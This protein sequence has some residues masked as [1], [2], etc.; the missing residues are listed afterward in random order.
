MKE[1][2][3]HVFI[4]WSKGL[5]QR[6]KI[7][8]DI[9]SKFEILESVDVTWSKNKFSENLSRFYGENLPKNSSKEKHCG[10]GTFLC[11]IVRDNNPKYELRQTSKGVKPVNINMFD[12][13]Q[14]YR[15]WTGGG[16]K[17]HGSDNVIEARSNMYLLLGV[18]YD[19]IVGLEETGKSRTYDKNLIGANGW[20]SLHEIF[21]A[22]NELCNYVVLRNFED[23]NQEL[24]NLHPDID[25]LTDNKR[26]I[27][28]ISNG[29]PTKKDKKRV[30]HLVSINNQNVFFDFR[31]IGDNYYDYKWE[32]QIL[33]TRVI[34]NNLY[35]PNPINHFY[36][37]MY[38]AFIHKPEL[39]EDYLI[40]LIDISHDIDLN[41]DYKSFI[42][43][44][45]LNDLNAFMISNN[46]Q[47]V[48]PRDLSVYFNTKV[49]ENFENILLSKKR[50]SIEK[51]WALKK[52]V[53]R[54]LQK[55]GFKFGR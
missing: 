25:L 15:K 13:K 22:F 46:Y 16:H 7:N 18:K 44:K 24:N 21:E 29:K 8:I 27:A 14:L 47:Y 40:K 26:L 50:D 31:F 23:I 54:V 48:E 3:A 37:L 38:H 36:S 17:I 41:Y 32:Q 52:L 5:Q 42:N 2:E 43:L 11:V 55:M 33:Y 51:K 19:L 45:T 34:Y 53:K 20:D 6:D 49:I 28:D 30:Q 35:I 10:T 9:K 1:I 12:A 39:T 4:I